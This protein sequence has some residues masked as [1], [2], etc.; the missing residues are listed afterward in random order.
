MALPL[1]PDVERVPLHVMFP[2]E[3]AQTRRMIV[4]DFALYGA[5]I[6]AFVVGFATIYR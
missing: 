3:Y 5:F 1:I 2:E 4:R 6:V